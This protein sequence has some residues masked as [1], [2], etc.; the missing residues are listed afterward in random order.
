MKLIRFWTRL[1]KQ[2]EFYDDLQKLRPT[3][4]Q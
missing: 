1:I 4:G 2:P 3:M